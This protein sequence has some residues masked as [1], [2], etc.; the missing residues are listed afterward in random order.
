MSPIGVLVSSFG[1]ERHQVQASE[2]TGGHSAP[3][4]MPG[5]EQQG[6]LSFSLAVFILFG[7]DSTTPGLAAYT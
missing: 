4:L 3:R 6:A 2:P 1:K 7:Y 5:F